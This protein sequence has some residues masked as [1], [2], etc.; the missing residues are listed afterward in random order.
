MSYL[1]ATR[2][3]QQSRRVA[4]RLA[5]RKNG[6]KEDPLSKEVQRQCEALNMTMRVRRPLQG[7]LR[8][9]I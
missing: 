9:K 1:Q 3:P 5:S 4:M 2:S 7:T 8:R 6:K